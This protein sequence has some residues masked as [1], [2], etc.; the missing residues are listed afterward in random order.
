MKKIIY[1][2]HKYEEVYR[3]ECPKCG[4]V[5]L[6]KDEDIKKD[7]E[8]IDNKTGNKY[9]KCPCCENSIDDYWGFKNQ[10]ITVTVKIEPKEAVLEDSK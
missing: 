6:F 1:Y 4:C 9:I 2:G 5:F 10:K 3:V 7:S 8:A